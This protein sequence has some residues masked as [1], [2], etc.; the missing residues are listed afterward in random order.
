MQPLSIDKLSYWEQKTYFSSTDFIVIGAGI[1]GYS[2]ALYLRE[3]HPDASI[4]ILERGYLPSGASSKNAGFACFGS[5]TELY[6]DLQHITENQVWDT[7]E[8]RWNGLQ[9]LFSIIPKEKFDF[10]QNGS[11]DLIHSN[12]PQNEL[13]KDDFI[14][15]LNDNAEKITGAKNIYSEDKNVSNTF[16]FNHISTSYFNRLEGQIDTSQLNKAF[17]QKTIAQNINCLFGVNV[18]HFQ[19]DS[20]NILLDTNIG[21]IKGAHLFICTNGLASDFFPEKVKPARAQV[22]ITE[23]I[24][25]LALKGTFHYQKGYYYFRNI[26]NRILLGGGRNLDFKGETTTEFGLTEHIQSS[27]EELLYNTISPSYKPKIEHRWSGI[28]GV[29]DEKKPIIEKISNRIAI[30]VRM[31]GMGVAIGSQVGKQLSELF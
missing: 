20:N 25:N 1:V 28:M 24:P 8:M 10:Q 15:Y 30:G 19:E 3:R 22:L 27:L 14:A 31:G 5:P 18:N 9:R 13:L 21:E 6:D 23:P 12:T 17:Y 7:L 16:G 29:G 4:L 11:W 26:D 2:T